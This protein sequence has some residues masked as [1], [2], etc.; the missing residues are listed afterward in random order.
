LPPEQHRSTTRTATLVIILITTFPLAN[1]I[2]FSR[3]LLS[4]KI[5]TADC[6]A[7]EKT[8]QLTAQQEE[9]AIDQIKILIIET[10]FFLEEPIDIS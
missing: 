1:V 4:S 8:I 5:F 2:V 3:L 9:H 7:D 10:T 6:D